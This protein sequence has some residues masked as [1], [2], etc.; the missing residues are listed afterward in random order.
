MNRKEIKA[1]AKKFAFSNK[2]NIWKP[3]LVVALIVG[4]AG[5]ILGA[6]GLGPE[7]TTTAEGVTTTTYSSSGA[8][9]ISSLLEVLLI[10]LTVGETYYIINLVRGKKLE[11]KEI[12]SK[13]KLILPI[14][15][16][17]LLVG[18]F[19]TLWTLLFIIPGIIY[20]FK[21]AMVPNLLADE[22]TNETG[23]M[24]LINRSK[25]LMDGHKWE[26]F[27]FN[28]SFIGWDLLVIITLGIAAIWV[29]PYETTAKIMYYD[30]LKK[31]N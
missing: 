17:T 14:F 10:P 27:I 6:F 26:Y 11:I 30:E 16:I 8:A 2:W 23:Y 19:T 12:F 24:E 31:L 4:L 28:L 25:K 9:F 22:L 15:V 5:G 21:V 1:R 13:Y 7:I 3:M 29:V 20:G 18:L